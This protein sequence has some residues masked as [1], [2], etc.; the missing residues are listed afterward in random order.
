MKELSTVDEK[1]T[2]MQSHQ[3]ACTANVTAKRLL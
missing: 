2:L 1:V 3:C